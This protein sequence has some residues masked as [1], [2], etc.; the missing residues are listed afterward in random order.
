MERMQARYSGPES[1][2]CPAGFPVPPG[3][4]E[5][6]VAKGPK[7]DKGTK[8]DRG[9]RGEQGLSH[10]VRYGIVVLFIVAVAIAATGLFV[11]VRGIQLADAAAAKVSH[12]NALCNA[13]GQL[14]SLPPP[15]GPAASN[16][17]RSFE[18]RE[19]S[20]L[21]RLHQQLGCDK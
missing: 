18:Q 5:W 20:I 14:G 9:D 3:T 1:L 2:L 4:K 7:G 11:G 6:G 19:H 12:H 16:P 17:S 8:G 10:R 15:P 13:I 21:V